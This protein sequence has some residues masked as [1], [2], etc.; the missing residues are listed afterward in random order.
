MAVGGSSKEAVRSYVVLGKESS[1]GTYASAT[2]AVEAISCNIR[3][4]VET[5]KL[6]QIGINRGFSHRVTLGKNVQG[7]F[8]QYLHPIDSVLLVAN[9]LGG[10]LVSNAG[11]TTTVF[12]HSISAGNYDT[13]TAINSLSFNIRKG[14]TDTFRYMGGKVDKLKLSGK[15]GEPLMLSADLVFKDSTLQSDDIS[16]NLS[17]SAVVPYTFAGGVFRY[18]STEAAAATTASNEPIQS[19]ELTISNN[20]VSDDNAR[21]LGTITVDVL[22][23]TRREIEFKVTNRWDTTTT[24][25]RFIQAT[26]GAAELFISGPAIDAGNNYEMTIRLPQ[27]YNVTGDTEI[28]GADEVLST[29]ITFDVIVSGNPATTTSRDI[30]VT[31]K[32]NVTAY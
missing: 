15:V 6:D 1:F 7:T 12:A 29:E 3:T 25:N 8:E 20:I 9:A 4:D 14:Q 19:F 26:Q 23:A 32:N 17:I 11:N 5:E 30:G 2:T 28:S 18:S 22:P 24:Y 16:A 27:I 31:V 21:S 10:P 13:T